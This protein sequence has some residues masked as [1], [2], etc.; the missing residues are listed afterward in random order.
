MESEHN[1]TTEFNYSFF[2]NI[3][4]LWHKQAPVRTSIAPIY[5]NKTQSTSG[6]HLPR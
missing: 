2:G 4:C 6:K 3:K 5:H 1:K